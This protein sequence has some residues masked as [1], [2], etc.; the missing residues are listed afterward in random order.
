MRS[1]Q[2]LGNEPGQLLLL[3]NVT[4]CRCTSFAA[5]AGAMR[6]PVA[7]RRSLRAGSDAPQRELLPS[8]VRLMLAFGDQRLTRDLVLA[9]QMP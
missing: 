5:T 6:S 3:D 4:K 2:L 8:G 9:P 1:Q 7:T